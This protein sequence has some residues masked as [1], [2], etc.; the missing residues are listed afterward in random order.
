MIAKPTITDVVKTVSRK[1]A[2][3]A[4][5]WALR[6]STAMK[7]TL[8][9]P[10]MIKPKTIQGLVQP[11]APACVTDA[12]SEPRAITAVI[13]PDR[14]VR[15]VGAWMAKGRAPRSATGQPRRW[16]D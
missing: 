6:R 1:I 13:W 8:A 7:A 3:G 2:N 10:A 5:G 15:S 16:E 4:M 9:A 11:R 12:A 14:S